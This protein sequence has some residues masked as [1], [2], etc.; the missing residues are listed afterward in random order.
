MW[1]IAKENSQD[2]GFAISCLFSRSIS[3]PEFQSWLGIV[4]TDVPIEK[5]P[6]YVYDLMDFNDDLANIDNV[7]GFVAPSKLS[8]QQKNALIGIAYSRNIDVYDSPISKEKA[9]EALKNNPHIL[10]E[11]KRFFPF[12]E[13]NIDHSCDL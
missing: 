1:K 5:I 10:D 4:V 3:L 12:I 2:L 8:T 11:F 7:I 13:L 9:L 6:F